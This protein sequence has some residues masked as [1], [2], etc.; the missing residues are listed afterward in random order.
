MW[1]VNMLDIHVHVWHQ[2][3][4]KE[5]WE[6]RRILSLICIIIHIILNTWDVDFLLTR[7]A[8]FLLHT[9]NNRIVMDDI[10]ETLT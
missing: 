2:K 6:E 7:C 5:P 10:V 8:K 9:F 1:N 3:Y 4:A